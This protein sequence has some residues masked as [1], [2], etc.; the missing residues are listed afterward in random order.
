MRLAVI[1]VHY[2][3]PELLGPACEALVRDAEAGGLELEGLVVDNG[4]RPEDRRLLAALPFPCLAAEGNLGYAG[5]ANLGLRHTT[6]ELAVVMNPDVLVLPGCLTA[7][8]AALSTCAAAGPRFY[9]D[10]GRHFLLP[11]TEPVS[12]RG[13]IWRLLARRGEG[14]ARRGRRRWRRH[15]RRHW[16]AQRP[17]RTYDLSGALLALRRSAWEQIGPFDEAYRLYFE[18]TDWLWRLRRAGLGARLVPAAEAVHLYAQSVR[19]EERADAWFLASS[20]RFRRRVFGRLFTSLL[21]LASRRVAAAPPPAA[22]GAAPRP[23][24]IADAAWLEVSPTAAGVPAAGRRL[25]RAAAEHPG[26][27]WS[28]PPEIWQRLAAGTYY[29]RTVDESGGDL[30]L[31][32]V[33]KPVI[34]RGLRLC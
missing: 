28:L 23:A 7:L 30:E 26:D 18:E 27:V 19:R 17:F 3:T 31:R 25:A 13:E 10:R 6:A 4:S 21:E 32:I 5:G 34:G 14:W 9:W 33:D 16:L 8:A 20:R 2:H 11:P 29:L 24:R 1:L 22:G 15:A 12:R